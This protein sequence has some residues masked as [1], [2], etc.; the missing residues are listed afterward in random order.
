MAYA[1]Q[2]DGVNDYVSIPQ[3]SC[4]DGF[5]LEFIFEYL[6]DTSMIIGAGGNNSFWI[7]T[8]GSS[9]W[10]T[11]FGG[12]NKGTL[13]TYTPA[14][15]EIVSLK[16]SREN[17]SSTVTLDINGNTGTFASTATLLL[18]LFCKNQFGYFAN[19]NLRSV[20]VENKSTTTNYFYDPSATS[21]VGTTLEDTGATSNDGTLFGGT[22]VISQA[23]PTDFTRLGSLTAPSV[24]GS[25]SDLPTLVK[26]E[27][28]TSTMLA[29]LD[30]GGGDLRFSSDEAG[31]TQLACEVVTFTKAT[32]DVVWVKVPAVSTGALIY[33]WGDNT[34]ATQPA[35][36]A[37]F[38]RN[39]VW[40]DVTHK[41]G[42]DGVTDST[43]LSTNINLIAGATQTGTVGGFNAVSFT[44]TSGQCA[45]FSGSDTESYLGDLTF[46]AWVNA[47]S[48][49]GS[50]AQVLGIRSQS[51]WEASLRLEG[52]QPAIIVG[53]SS[54]NS[55][56]NLTVATDQ[57]VV[58]TISGTSISFYLDG[59]SIG[60]A[61]VAGTRANRSELLAFGGVVGANADL[62]LDGKIAEARAV[63]GTAITS[64]QVA[65]EYDNQSA[66]GAWWTAADEGGSNNISYALAFDG[67]NDYVNLSTPIHMTGDFKITFS[68]I[69]PSSGATER[70]MGKGGSRGAREGF[71]PYDATRMFFRPG[72]DTRT[73]YLDIQA[74]A[75]DL[76]EGTFERIGAN[77]ILTV[78]SFTNSISTTYDAYFQYIG[79]LGYFSSTLRSLSIEDN[80]VL[81]HKYDPSATGG[82]GSVLKDTVG[83]NDGALV[84]FPT[85]DS[86]WV[87]YDNLAANFTRLGSLTAPSVTGL[88]ANLPT[89]VKF[90][91]FTSTMLASLDAGGGDLRF[92]SDVDGLYPLACEVVTFTKATG[93]VVWVKVPS[94]ATGALIY[95]WGDN[96]GASQP[97]VDAAFGRN[98]VWVNRKQSLHMNNNPVGSILDSSVNASDMSATAMAAGNL[99]AGAVGDALD[100]DGS[101]EY[102]SSA[103]VDFT[104]TSYAS[105]AIV[106]FDSL[107]G[108]SRNS[109]L[110]ARASATGTPISY[111]TGTSPADQ[112]RFLVRDNA[113][114]LANATSAVVPTVGQYYWV[115]GVRTGDNIELFVDGVSVA[116]ATAT[117]GTL[118]VDTA[119][120]GVDDSVG[121]KGAFFDGIIDEVSLYDYAPTSD[122]LSIEYDNQSATGAWWT[123][124]DEGGGGG[125]ADTYSFSVI[126]SSLTDTSC[127]INKLSSESVDLGI[128]SRIAA[129]VSKMASAAGYVDGSI[130]QASAVNKTA[131]YSGTM[132]LSATISGLFTST[133]GAA[134]VFIFNGS[135][136]L[137]AG[138]YAQH[139]KLGRLDSYTFLSV[140]NSGIHTKTAHNIATVNN[141]GIGA[142]VQYG[143]YSSISS[144]LHLRVDDITSFTKLTDNAATLSWALAVSGSVF[145]EDNVVNA[146]SMRIEGTSV[147]SLVKFGVGDGYF[148][149]M[150]LKVIKRFDGTVFG[151][152]KRFDGGFKQ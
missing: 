35:V 142:T 127:A 53:T 148:D 138:S 19:V 126:M 8:L 119:F 64:D 84:S 34:G 60:T 49:V 22:W 141:L 144:A 1:L 97:A 32:G 45:A 139:K 89:L 150:A 57:L 136:G 14:M 5:N 123:A 147:A 96:T 92:S 62:T 48:F 100:F 111:L 6:G 95:V 129:T 86:Q 38:G 99:M 83:T 54:P 28:F 50:F 128:S 72:A 51:L 135:M 78:G 18:E 133:E 61:S 52:S 31:T 16:L 21:G 73:A 68:F 132:G 149:G 27:D 85:D 25:A 107:G 37:A 58:V 42:G 94:V 74:T 47:T 146:Y 30:S 125:G 77:R 137:D 66:T 39:A 20:A 102:L 29:N 124:A 114:N 15:N 2:F 65:I 91:D 23:F 33:V 105:G 81:I 76:I 120:V 113:G 134:E 70:I 151:I 103:K 116:T 122:Q 90:E 104:S 115:V 88:A 11:R 87:E 26:Y 69:W 36:G 112:L 145:N 7:G 98:A 43:G 80:G 41:Q 121:S 118:G 117:L 101:A 110:Q 152:N 109:I 44:N 10:A 143:K 9:G 130:D 46:S 4:S 71:G 40:V 55:T 108:S 3:I 79:Q 67:V 56:G 140:S 12:S 106:K 93:D 13:A 82:T 17:G 59:N 131:S 63:N 24:T 75:G